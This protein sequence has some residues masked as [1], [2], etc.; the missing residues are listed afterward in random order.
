MGQIII[1]LPSRIKRHYR[2]DNDEM[3]KLILESLEQSATIIKTN[4][5]KLSAE[6]EQD[7]RDARRILKKGDFVTL[8]QAKA[9]LGLWNT[10]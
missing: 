10:K 1:E 3:E 7:I 9:E 2:L 8:E 6:D 5:A 4:P